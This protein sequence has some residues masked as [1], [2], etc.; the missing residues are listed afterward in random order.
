MEVSIPACSMIVFNHLAMVL[1][2][3]ALWGLMNDMNN[4]I[5]SPRN[6][7][8]LSTYDLRVF[9]GHKT[10]FG[11][12]DGKKNSSIGLPWRDCF[13][14]VVGKNA[15]PSLL[16]LILAI[17]SC[18]RSAVLDGRVIASRRTVFRV[19]VLSGRSS[20]LPQDSK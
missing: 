5:S 16:G 19:S 17:F 15:T 7:L 13:A 3:T 2:V 18:D 9:T 10:V 14:R 20:D 8:V 4:L 6:G 11:K 12:K 1:D